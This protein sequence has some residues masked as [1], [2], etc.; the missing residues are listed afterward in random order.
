LQSRSKNCL[1]TTEHGA[2]KNQSTA[3]KVKTGRLKQGGDRKGE[4][5]ETKKKKVCGGHSCTPF[6]EEA[7]P[8]DPRGRQKPKGGQGGGTANTFSLEPCVG[9]GS[10][11]DSEGL[12]YLWDTGLIKSEREQTFTLVVNYL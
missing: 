9:V 6:E 11:C 8:W 7:S 10:G 12:R 1:Q 5:S 2:S 4:M 3:G